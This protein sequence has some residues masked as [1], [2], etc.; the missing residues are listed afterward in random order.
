M[1]HKAICFLVTISYVT[2]LESH[3]AIGEPCLLWDWRAS[4][5]RI[6]D[7]ACRTLLSKEEIHYLRCRMISNILGF[8]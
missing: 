7:M 8:T 3:P 6:K 1:R 2:L 4:N 5:G